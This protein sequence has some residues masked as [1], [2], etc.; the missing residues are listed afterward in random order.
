[1]ALTTAKR[2]AQNQYYDD[3]LAEGLLPLRMML[4]PGGTFQMGSPEEEL[5]RVGSEGPQHGV[6]VPQFFMAKYPVTQAQWRVVSS[7]PQVNH[8]LKPDPS[9][10][11]GDLRPVEQVSWYEAVEFCDR[12]TVH[13]NRQYRLP[14]EAEWEYACRA[15]T[16]TP[17]HF[18]ET[19]STDYANYD[20]ANE[21]YGAYG[22]GTKGEYRG[23]TTPVDHF[24]VA[25]A[26]GLC[27]MHENVL[28]WCQ[29]LMHD[30][31]DGAPSDGSAW[32]TEYEPTYRVVRGGSWNNYPRYCRSAVRFFV[33][34]ENSSENMGFRVVC[35]A[36]STLLQ[37]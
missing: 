6:T 20:G 22:P 31:Y 35:S 7:M 2:Q 33:T 37:P 24:D 27:D 23:E 1:M 13:T 26:Y 4:I 3:P 10:F 8:E 30:S 34:P 15:G 17:F 18:G 25:N 11:K 21:N 28:E 9:N 14:T 19:L 16:T 29:D 5:E 36:P 32:L 12:I